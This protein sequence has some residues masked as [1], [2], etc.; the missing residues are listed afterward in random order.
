MLNNL[1][2]SDSLTLICLI[3][4]LSKL[5]IAYDRYNSTVGR[6]NVSSTVGQSAAIQWG[7]RLSDVLIRTVTRALH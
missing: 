2:L 5:M 7:L 4:M 3:E 1:S 6:S